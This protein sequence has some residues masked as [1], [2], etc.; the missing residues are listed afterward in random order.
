MSASPD[1]FTSNSVAPWTAK[2]QV[3]GVDIPFKLV[4]VIAITEESYNCIGEKKLTPPDNPVCRP[5][6]NWLEVTGWFAGN[7]PYGDR[8]AEQHIFVVQGLRR[9]LHQQEH[10]AWL[11]AVLERLQVKGVMLNADKC[12]FSKTS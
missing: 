10:D 4:G 6:G 9:N 7:L 2:I 8:S 3:F 11:K 12:E 1:A 5:S